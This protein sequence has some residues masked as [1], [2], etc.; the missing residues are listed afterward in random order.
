MKHWF[1][2]RA[3]AC[4]R[5]RPLIQSIACPLSPSAR[6]QPPDVANSLPTRG[7]RP[8]MT[9]T[10]TATTDELLAD[11]RS[12]SRAPARPRRGAGSRPRHF[13]ATGRD[14]SALRRA[15]RLETVALGLRPANA[16]PAAATMTATGIG[17]CRRR[18][19][20]R[21]SSVSAG[22]PSQSR[23]TST[24][25]RPPRA[26]VAPSPPITGSTF[27]RSP[28]SRAGGIPAGPGS[29]CGPGR[30]P[31]VPIPGPSCE[32]A[33]RRRPA[34][35]PLAAPPGQAQRRAHRLGL[36]AQHRRA[37]PHRQ[38]TDAAEGEATM[39]GGGLQFLHALA[40]DVTDGCSFADY[41]ARR[42]MR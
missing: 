32:T 31:S 23:R 41:P 21:I 29:S 33:P 25:G 12:L 18:S 5:H 13:R 6:R 26:N 42:A 1:G 38:A 7:D 40:K 34:A 28:I 14:G 11:L 20:T 35:P 15:A 8:M 30:W 19:T 16:S 39:T 10:M 22:T 3:T 27:A 2:T 17:R 9:P 4:H 24:T 37:G 36:R